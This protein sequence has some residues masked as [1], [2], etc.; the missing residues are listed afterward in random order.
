MNFEVKFPWFFF[1]RF[2]EMFRQCDGSTILALK[3]VRREAPDFFYQ[4]LWEL[5][6]KEKRDK[7]IAILKLTQA[8]DSL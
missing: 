6:S 4:R 2:S 8:L 5:D 7:L 3:K 1:H